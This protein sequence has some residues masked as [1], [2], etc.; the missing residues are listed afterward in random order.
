MLERLCE[1][2]AQTQDSRNPSNTS[3]LHSL[4]GITLLQWSTTTCKFVRCIIT[5]LRRQRRS[6]KLCI[7]LELELSLA[8]RVVTIEF[9]IKMGTRWQGRTG[10]G[11]SAWR[12][13]AKGQC[14]N[15]I[16]CLPP[17]LLNKCPLSY[18][19]GMIATANAEVCAMG[20]GTQPLRVAIIVMCLEQYR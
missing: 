15:P 17:S 12:G 16:R 7:F 4:L 8:L 9:G 19:S 5:R 2:D 3:R 13:E 6:L 1:R 18:V 14:D 20:E 10:E 11:G